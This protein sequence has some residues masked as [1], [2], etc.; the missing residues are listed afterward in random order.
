MTR[1]GKSAFNNCNNLKSIKQ[2][3]GIT[4]IEDSTFSFCG[5]TELTIPE[6][7]TEIGVDAFSYTKGN[8]AQRMCGVALNA[9]HVLYAMHGIFF[10]NVTI[11]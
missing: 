8:T 6:G 5:L 4:K 1:I 3:S 7:V 9:P 11:Q 10:Q 2:P